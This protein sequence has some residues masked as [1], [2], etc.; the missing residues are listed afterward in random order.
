MIAFILY[1][2]CEGFVDCVKVRG[3]TESVVSTMPGCTVV[4]TTV[5]S[6]LRARSKVGLPLTVVANP[7]YLYGPKL[8]KRVPYPA[9]PAKGSPELRLVN[10]VEAC[11]RS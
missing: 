5:K 6:F 1:T 2:P 4:E 11:V 10:V 8:S 9:E 7:M 3:L